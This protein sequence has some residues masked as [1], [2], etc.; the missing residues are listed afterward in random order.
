MNRTPLRQAEHEHNLEV[1]AARTPIIDAAVGELQLRSVETARQQKELAE[2]TL[3]LQ[4]GVNVINGRVDI[5]EKELRMHTVMLKTI[6]DEKRYSEQ[7]RHEEW[8]ES[9]TFNIKET[10]D[11]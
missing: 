5:I 10:A 1:S 11:D 9:N 3:Q 7:V 4:K 6:A 8:N 2:L